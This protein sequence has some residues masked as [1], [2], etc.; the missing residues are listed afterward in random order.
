MDKRLINDCLELTKI[1]ERIIKN[2]NPEDLSKIILICKDSIIRLSKNPGQVENQLIK[3]F[4]DMQTHAEN[5][6][7]EGQHKAKNPDGKR[8]EFIL[9][10]VKEVKE[11]ILNYLEKS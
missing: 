10:D 11:I 1:S 5:L 9:R 6:L 7:A 8:A 4:L 2:Q 3:L